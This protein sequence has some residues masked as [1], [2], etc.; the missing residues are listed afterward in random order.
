M[1]LLRASVGSTEASD[2]RLA[3]VG[4]IDR[5]IGEPPCA[6]RCRRTNGTSLGANLYQAWTC[7]YG[8]FPLLGLDSRG[9]HLKPMFSVYSID[10]NMNIFVFYQRATRPA[11]V[12]ILYQ[13]RLAPKL[14]SFVSSDRRAQR[15]CR[16][17][18][19]PDGVRLESLIHSPGPIRSDPVRL[20]GPTHSSGP[21]RS[22]RVNHGIS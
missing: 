3:R 13:K 11:Q 22:D 10:N 15:G 2:G 4:R 8:F 20:E 6:R 1:R 21:I 18:S 12:Q 16:F 7:G 9:L 19:G 17:A 5:R 14:V